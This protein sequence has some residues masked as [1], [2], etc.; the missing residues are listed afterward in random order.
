MARRKNRTA[1]EAVQD[2]MFDRATGLLIAKAVALSTCECCGDIA[3]VAFDEARAEFAAMPLSDDVAIKLATALV[4]AVD[5]ARE[6]RAS[7]KAGV[8]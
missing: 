3:L 6:I 8:H 4:N 7:G 5:E 1:A 2:V